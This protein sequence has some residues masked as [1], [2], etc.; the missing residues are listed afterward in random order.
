ML[1]AHGI[2]NAPSSS[3]HCNTTFGLPRPTCTLQEIDPDIMLSIEHLDYAR[4]AHVRPGID[5][6]PPTRRA[7][8]T[9]SC[10]LSNMP[11]IVNPA[12]G[13][14]TAV[15]FCDD[16]GACIRALRTEVSIFN[17]VK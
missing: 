14:A 16:L 12:V 5:L 3:F 15:A 11:V 6:L 8:H 4:E 9:I 2:C 1:P 10:L 17:L 13:R 7:L